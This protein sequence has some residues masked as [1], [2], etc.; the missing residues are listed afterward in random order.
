MIPSSY[1]NVMSRQQRRFSAP[2]KALETT[3]SPPVHSLL[4][5][6][7]GDLSPQPHS[8]QR[9]NSYHQILSSSTNSLPAY[10]PNNLKEDDFVDPL[11]FSKRNKTIEI[12]DDDICDD[13]H[14]LS[15]SFSKFSLCTASNNKR[16]VAMSNGW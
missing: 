9:Q 5:R 10:F 16:V 14:S 12:H 7:S 2:P 13:T 11:F 15:N 1:N 8:Y 3:D 6:S 4:W